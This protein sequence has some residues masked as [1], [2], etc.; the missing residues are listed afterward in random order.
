MNFTLHLTADCNLSCRYCYE[1]HAKRR[2]T[3]ETAKRA[4]DL[5]FSYGHEKNGFSLFGGEP[6][7]E[8]ATIESLVRYAA[9][10]AKKTGTGL[11]FKILA[12][13]AFAGRTAR[14][15]R[16]EPDGGTA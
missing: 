2:M 6:L 11:R 16:R 14:H 4:V 1:T 5:A 12:R 7:L 8:R 13:R 10:K 15:A 3:E 9:E